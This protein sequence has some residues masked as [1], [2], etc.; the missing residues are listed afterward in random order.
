[1]NFDKFVIFEPKE[2]PVDISQNSPNLSNHSVNCCSPTRAHSTLGCTAYLSLS[3]D[4]VKK[5]N[6]YGFSD[7]YDPSMMLGQIRT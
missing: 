1:M 3:L 2:T 4:C 5:L 7:G 6:T